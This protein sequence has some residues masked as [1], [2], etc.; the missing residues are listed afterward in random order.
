[1][2]IIFTLQMSKLRAQCELH[3]NTLLRKLLF[4]PLVTSPLFDTPQLVPKEVWVGDVVGEGEG[5]H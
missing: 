3:K 5:T 4:K 2:T 1:M